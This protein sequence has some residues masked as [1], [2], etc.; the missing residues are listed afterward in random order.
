M[1][2]VDTTTEAAALIGVNPEAIT[3]ENLAMANAVIE[4]FINREVEDIP[5]ITPR[6]LRRIQKAVAWQS[7]YLADQEDFGYRTLLESASADG[8]NFEMATRSLG[9]VDI[10]AQTLHPLAYRML[11]NLS[12]KTPRN[13]LAVSDILV[14]RYRNF[15]NE[16]S[17]SSHSW[18]DEL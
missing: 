12:W 1:S 10:A 4:V 9:G 17:D 11:K 6:D 16:A 18:S 14:S 7:L 2:W 3:T 5:D 8:Q 15:L 13:S